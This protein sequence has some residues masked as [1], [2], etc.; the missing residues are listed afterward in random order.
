M[1]HQERSS[2]IQ[3]VLSA[4]AECNTLIV[5]TGDFKVFAGK[6]SSHH[7]VAERSGVTGLGGNF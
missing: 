2:L 4:R 6:V 3:K 1:K 7:K 5:L